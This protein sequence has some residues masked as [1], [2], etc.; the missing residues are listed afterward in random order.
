MLLIT[1]LIHTRC[2]TSPLSP[3]ARWAWLRRYGGIWGS[4]F[5][6]KPATV[7]P[8]FF[9]LPKTWL[10]T[11]LE[12]MVSERTN[13]WTSY[14]FARYTSLLQWFSWR[15]RALAFYRQ[16]WEKTIAYWISS[17][18][19]STND[20][21]LSRVVGFCPARLALRQISD[22]LHWILFYLLAV[23]WEWT[24]YYTGTRTMETVG[25][26]RIRTIKGNLQGIS[27]SLSMSNS[28]LTTSQQ[29]MLVSPIWFLGIS[30]HNGC[31]HQSEIWLGFK[32]FPYSENV[33]VR[34]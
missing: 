24:L 3:P 7:L 8:Q 22:C 15:P 16:I 30:G 31:G 19:R 28:V 2:R 33:W 5:K 32:S 13:L 1:L 21:V 23:W 26:L 17:P 20:P 6:S 34:A 18:L 4:S 10:L 11:P 29:T 14:Y 25:Y 12:A 27:T 9:S